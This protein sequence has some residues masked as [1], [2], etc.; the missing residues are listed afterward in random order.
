MIQSER[1]YQIEQI[2]EAALK[3]QGSERAAFLKE[4][5]GEDEALR[6]EVEQL[7][8]H[9]ETA[10]TFLESPALEAA[11]KV[12][13]EVQGASRV[14]QQL[15]AYRILSLLGA[16]GIGEVYLAKDTSLDRRVAIKFLP[17]ESTANQ[18]AKKR[19]IREAKAR[20][21]PSPPGSSGF[22]TSAWRRIVSDVFKRW[23]RFR[24]I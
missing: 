14:G 7:L 4:A 6:R 5:C 21:R 12:L 13:A 19:L 3:R 11:A 9:E 16:G 15:G 20:L 1:R 22:C 17:Q 18:Q 10:K 2:C 24:P 8:S 23:Q